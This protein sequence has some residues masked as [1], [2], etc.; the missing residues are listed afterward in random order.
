MSDN[1]NKRSGR[2]PSVKRASTKRSGIRVGQNAHNV[3]VRINPLDGKST[4]EKLEYWYDVT[5]RLPAQRT[6]PWYA[7]R[8]NKLTAS[9]LHMCL[10]WTDFEDELFNN[11][12]FQIKKKTKPKIGGIIVRNPRHFLKERVM[13]ISDG[14]YF[15]GKAAKHGNTFEDAVNV[16]YETRYDTKVHE[17]GCL[18]H[19]TIEFL[20]A[21][22][23]GI[24]ELG[25]MIEIKVPYSRTI[26]YNPLV[27]YWM[28]TQLQME[29]CNFDKTRFIECKVL[30]YKDEIEY[31]ADIDPNG[32]YGI[33]NDGME[34]GCVLKWYGS[35]I[36]ELNRDNYKC[37]PITFKN[38]DEMLECIKEK[39]LD[40]I[41]QYIGKE[42]AIES[43]YK[44]DGKDLIENLDAGIKTRKFGVFNPNITTNSQYPPTLYIRLKWFKMGQFSMK[45]IPRDRDWFQA[46]LPDLAEFWNKVLDYRKNGLPVDYLTKRDKEKIQQR[47]LEEDKKSGKSRCI[48]IEDS[49]DLLPLKPLK[50][51]APTPVEFMMLDDSDDDAEESEELLPPRTTT[52]GRT[53]AYKSKP[54]KF[55]ILDDSSDGV[56]NGVTKTNVSVAQKK[57]TFVKKTQQKPKKIQFMIM[58]DS[59]D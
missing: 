11:G 38:H 59:S 15:T 43:F 16:V 47:Q 36:D 8:E 21:S 22:P 13:T 14:K 52:T 30:K 28:Q 4:Q 29:V 18:P 25:Y 41:E 10:S 56:T 17:F 48:I 24:D 40:L 54:N 50:S 9:S 19:P 5:S 26:K 42:Y 31:L 2:R 33:N 20:A 44:I 55:M 23:D 35:E 1:N 53:T 34:K 37:L 27:E 49:D 58:D 32:V 46:R 12:V 45:E 57:S 7:Y 3:N 39:V 51:P 6:P